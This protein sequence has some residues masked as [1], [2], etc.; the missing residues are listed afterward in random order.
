MFSKKLYNKC[1]IIPINQPL[2]ITNNNGIYKFIG[3]RKWRTSNES[4]F[5]I[6]PNNKNPELPYVKGFQRTELDMLWRYL[7]ANQSITMK[8]FE[9]LCPDLIKEG[10]CCFA[11]FY[12][13][14]DYLYPNC[15]T[16][17]S[18]SI[19]TENNNRNDN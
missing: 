13:L 7:L 2:H 8:D 12:G 4:L 14:I 5:Y 16:K 17:N 18:K 10:K 9:K 11:A 15:F 19:K 1:G 3:L 6:I